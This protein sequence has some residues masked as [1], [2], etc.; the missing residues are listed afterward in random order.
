[1]YVL[2]IASGDKESEMKQNLTCKVI[3]LPALSTA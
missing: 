1:M 2:G 3:L